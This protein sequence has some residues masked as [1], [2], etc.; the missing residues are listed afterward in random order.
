MV[1]PFI[2]IV[3]PI[4]NVEAYLSRCVD[5]LLNQTMEEIEIILVNDNSPDNC[6]VLCD[7]YAKKDNRIKVIH[8]ENGGLSDARN[9]GLELAQGDYVLFVDSDDYID[10]KTCEYFYEYLKDNK[11]DVAIGSAIKVEG[12]KLSKFNDRT[13]Y[14]VNKTLTGNEFLKTGYKNGVPSMAVWC[15]LYNNDFLRRNNLFFKKGLLHEDEQ[16][17]PRVFLLAKKVLVTEICFYNYVI[18]EGSITNSNNFKKN[19]EH[20][21]ETVN[22]LNAIFETLEDKELK[23]MLKNNLVTL[24]LFAFRKGKLYEGNKKAVNK[25]FVLINALSLQNK[26]KSLVFCVS[27]KLYSSIVK[28]AM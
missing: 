12:S 6:P 15:N 8:K 10:I 14:E 4:Y 5:S 18:R 27:P 23:K 24:Y 11:V 20:I 16:W 25:K 3:V 9:A 7:S 2:S 1:R 28:K 26:L 17:T 21:I 22:E 19:A 13:P